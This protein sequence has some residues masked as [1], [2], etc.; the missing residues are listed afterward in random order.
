MK[1]A[2][3]TGITGTLGEALGKL[4]KKKGWTVYGVTR[5]PLESHPA[6]DHVITNEQKSIDDV[7]ALLAAYPDLVF[8]NAGAIEKEIGPM[9]EP[10]SDVTLS[11][12]NINY[13]F[14]AIFSLE[15]AKA[16]TRPMD[17]IAIGS[18]ADGSPSAFGP[19]YHA[20]K[21][22]L[23]YF[24]Q[25]TGPI[26]NHANPNIRVRLY[27]PGA[28]YG[29]LSWAPVNR[30][31]ERGYKIRAKRCENAPSANKVALAVARFQEG[32]KLVACYDEPIGFK[33]LKFFFALSPN[34]YYKLQFWA[35]RN[36]CKFVA[37]EPPPAGQMA[38]RSE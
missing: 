17:I 1:K 28:I 37:C 31:N 6:C 15:A 3:I 26:L 5:K 25:G 24:I 20:S 12:T 36:A 32:K 27:R 30:L 34:L 16:A 2:L 18:I 29:P 7:N 11:M 21:I 4:Y 8:L 9:G 38:A 22:A 13:T 19:V 10:L 33:F 35:W 14:P 23:H